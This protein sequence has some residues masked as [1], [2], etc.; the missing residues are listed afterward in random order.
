MRHLTLIR[1]AKSSWKDDSLSDFDRPLNKRGAANAPLMGRILKQQGATFDLLVTSPAVRALTTARLIAAELGY[2]AE[3]LQE[4]PALYEA[5]TETMLAVIHNLPASATRV[6]LVGHNPT[7]TAVCNYLTGEQI[8]NLPT[9][10]VAGIVFEV[11]DWPAVWR[12]SGRLASYEFPRK[13]TG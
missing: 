11:D 12:G 10:A 6:G 1:H 3:R 8:E 2:P 5:G 7:L 13:Y 4:E 9:C